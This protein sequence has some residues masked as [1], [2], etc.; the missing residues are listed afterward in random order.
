M[1]DTTFARLLRLL[2]LI[3]P[4]PRTIDT[5]QLGALLAADDIDATPRTVQRDLVRL[6]K[7]GCGIECLDGS[8][9][10]RWRYGTKAR[11][12]VLPGIDLPQALALLLVEAHLQRLVPA[13]AWSALRVHL[14]AARRVV[15]GKPARRW[16]ERVRIIPR[17]QPLEAPVVDVAVLGAVQQAIVEE[18]VL[19]VRYRSA[20]GAAVR[21]MPLHPLGLVSREGVSYLVATAF[22]YVDVRLYALHRMRSA[23]LTEGRSRRPSG[24]D[25]DAFI[26]AGEVG[27]RLGSEPL[28][29]ELAFYDGAERAV[30]EAPLSR[31]QKVVAVDGAAIVSATV[32]DTRLLR[33]WLLGWGAAVEVRRPKALRDEM[34]KVLAAAAARYG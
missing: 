13:A 20:A 19:Q 21:D 12:F 5:N 24:F 22:D 31:D 17:A 14:D 28:S 2:Q 16:L 23:A 3:P 25:L 11:P 9:P 10:Y 33:S 15:D 18:R 1:S 29:V 8:K 27:W 7:M 34:K 32:A 4:H 26:A 30:L 6:E